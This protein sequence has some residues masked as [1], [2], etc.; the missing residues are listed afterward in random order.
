MAN[1]APGVKHYK[2]YL[3]N[4]EEMSNQ[5]ASV[6]ETHNIPE[7]ESDESQDNNYLSFQPPDPIQAGNNPETCHPTKM[8]TEDAQHTQN[9]ATPTLRI[10]SGVAT[11]ISK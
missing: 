11:Y 1:T 10:L 8:I 5:N 3:M 9:E 2:A 4:Q 6:F 7:D